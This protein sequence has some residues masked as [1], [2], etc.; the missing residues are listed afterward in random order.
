MIQS[1]TGYGKASAQS[2][3][4]KLSVEIR[5]LNSKTMDLNM[6]LPQL[7]RSSEIELRKL[8]T[9]ELGRGKVDFSLHV[10]RLG[11]SG[12]SALN[13]PLIQSYIQELKRISG[14]LG[15]ETDVL[16]LVMRLPDV[17]QHDREE[18]SE[19]DEQLL[20]QATKKAMHRLNDF[21]SEEGESMHRDIKNSIGKI[22][23]LLVEIEP[24][25]EDRKEG[26]RAKMNKLFEEFGEQLDRNRFEQELIYYFEKLD[27]NEEKVRLRQHCSYFIETMLTDRPGKKL[28]FISQE[29]GREINTLGSKSNQAEMQRIVV[30][31]KDELEKIKELALNIL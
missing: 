20:V 26:V 9:Q 16:S 7:F 27:V 13:E 3:N 29:I 11:A 1:M 17:I 14:N 22:E 2:E 10:E 5:S 25:D 6:R 24:Y 4:I 12:E 19:S 21:R 18:V 8:V 15:A 31:M 28:G 30:Q 23:A